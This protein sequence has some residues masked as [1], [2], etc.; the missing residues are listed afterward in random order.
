MK[1][2]V[3]TCSSPTDAPLP[4]LSDHEMVGMDELETIA[5]DSVAMGEVMTVLGKMMSE[6]GKIPLLNALFTSMT[7]E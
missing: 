1:V 5:E 2:N 4:D 6:L 3:W 7:A